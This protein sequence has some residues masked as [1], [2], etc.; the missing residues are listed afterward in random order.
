MILFA[1]LAIL[2]VVIYFTNQH[3]F[4]YWTNR[5]FPYKEPTFFLG[6][7]KGMITM[8]KSFGDFFTH[9]YENYKNKKLLGL[10]FTYRPTL[11]VNDPML[12]QEI[13]IKDFT[14]FHDRGFPVDEEIDPLGGHLFL[15]AGQRWRDLRVK[16]SPTFTSGKLKGM[17]PAI[18]DCGHVLQNYIEKEVKNGN[19][20]FDARDLLARFTTT[21]ISSVAFGIENDCIND[22]NNIF[23]KMGLK[24]FQPSFRQMVQDILGMFV[25]SVLIKL[26]IKQIPQDIEDFFMSVVKQS[27]DRRENNKELERKDF[28]QLLIQLKNQGYVSADKDDEIDDKIKEHDNKKLET[29]KLT[30]NEVAAQTFLFFV[31]GF[32]TSSS[33]S[34]LCLFELCRHPEIQKKVQK[35]IDEALK[36]ANTNEITYDILQDLKY[37]ECCV[38]EALR[39]YPI[40]PVLIRECTKDHT[41]SETNW[42]VEKGTTI[43]LPVQAL[44]R[45][46]NIYDNPMEFIPER[47]IDS[48]TGNGNSKGLYYLPFGDGPRNC[49]GARMGKLQTKLGLAMMLSKFSFELVDKSLLTKEFEVHPNQF[50]LTP[51]DNIMM[52]V[53]VRQ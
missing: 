13:M 52:K 51:K 27:I 18:N 8:K 5:G 37:L 53:K 2:A 21:V 41:F 17:Y 16:L 10:Y 15:L 31:A 28:M 23:R 4:S 47:F 35:E 1:L 42:T 43:F 12:I 11:L 25:P 9:I 14:S 38:D 40:V 45:D 3:Y 39:K 46:P 34:N 50:I 29:K 6:E 49:I 7:L 33:T 44:Q 22:P 36:A 26:K 48:P 20:V 24:I 32:E 19:D 30:F